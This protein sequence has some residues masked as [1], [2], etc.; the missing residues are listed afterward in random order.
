MKVSKHFS[1]LFISEVTQ[2]MEEES[3]SIV[4][5]TMEESAPNVDETSNEVNEALATVPTE[6]TP[7]A[8]PMEIGKQ[9]FTQEINV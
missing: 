4:T 7:L 3:E 1:F 9:L 6:V 5:G 2:A 8:S